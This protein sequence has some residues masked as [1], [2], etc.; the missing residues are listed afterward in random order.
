[1]ISDQQLFQ[2]F[3][4]QDEQSKELKAWIDLVDKA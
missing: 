2:N 1:M 3:R 4:L